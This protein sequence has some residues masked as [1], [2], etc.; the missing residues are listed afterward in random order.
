MIIHA[1]KKEEE[2]INV[3]ENQRK[4]NVEERRNDAAAAGIL[5]KNRRLQFL[6]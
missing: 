5:R 2:R 1:M 4:I 6:Q 3:R